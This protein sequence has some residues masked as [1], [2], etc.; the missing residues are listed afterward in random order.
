MR[1]WLP[2][3]FVLLALVAQPPA[4]RCV[5]WDEVADLVKD[6][7]CLAPTPSG[8]GFQALKP[9]EAVQL[10]FPVPKEKPAGFWVGTGSMVALSGKGTSYQLVLRVDAADGPVAYEGPVIRNGDDWNA[11]N[12][13]PVDV[14]A[15][16]TDAHARQG[17]VD[18]FAV[19]LTEGDGWALY[20][21]MKGRP[22]R[23]HVAE[24]TAEFR[25]SLETAKALAERGIAV[26][27]APRKIALREGE[28]RLSA[29]TRI[30]LSAK[31]DADDRFA[32]EDLAEQLSE[33]I[34]AK[35]A[36]TRSD[37]KPAAGTILLR[38]GEGK[39]ESYRLRVAPDGVTATGADA[40]GL[41]YAAQTIAQLVQGKGAEARLPA[42]EVEDSPAYPL[43]ALQYD[44]ARGQ[45]VNVEFM[46]R[47]IR[48]L[49]RCKLNAV[50]FYGEDDYRFVKYP[51]LGREGT[52]TPAKAKELSEYAHRYHL[53]LIPQFES[54][55]HASA[56]L[57]HPE[58]KHL[59]E[60]GSSWVFCTSNPKVWEFLDDCFRE[61]AEQ[62]P[63]SKYLHVGA[64][65]FEDGFG[66]CPQCK[67]KVAQAG[68]PGLY[69]EHM[70]RLNR[71][72][73]KY[74]R[75]ML[76]W[77]S[78]GA[79]TPER[80][81]LTFKAGKLLERDCI[82][83]EW[84]YHGPR[85]YPELRQYLDAG[86]QDCWTS[87]AVVC[88]SVIWPD[89]ETTFRGIRGMLRAGVPEGVKGTCTTTWEWMQGAMV[90]NSWL[91]MMYV[92]ECAW[93][94]GSTSRL[95]YQRR[96]AQRFYGLSGKD[97]GERIAQTLA[98][99]FPAK[100]EGARHRDSRLVRDILWC[101]PAQVRG[102]FA[103]RTGG[104]SAAAPALG[105][106]PAA[107]RERGAALRKDATRN[108]DLLAAAELAFRLHRLAARKVIAFDAAAKAYR[109]AA[110]LAAKEPAAAAAK[111]GEAADVIAALITEHTACTEA[112]EE[113]VQRYG[114]WHGDRD[115]CRRI[116][117][118]LEKLAAGV[119][120]AGQKL[121][122]GE[123]NS[124]PAGAQFG[125]PYG[126]YQRVGVWEPAQMNTETTS[127]R[128]DLSGKVQA[129]GDITLEWTYT[130]GAHALQ[131]DRV[132]LLCDGKEVAADV[133]HGLT[134]A[135]HHGNT[136]VLPLKEFQPAGRYEVVG[137]VR[138][139]GGTDSHGEVWLIL[140]DE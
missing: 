117:E 106:P 86:F 92:P 2:L 19:G 79:G 97:L 12:R 108:A 136:F 58:L 33:A 73:K 50:M 101:E 47:V 70:N 119:R 135:A 133:H 88:Y 51:F 98:R 36:V 100:G 76:F 80:S 128:I 46:K 115:N 114:H 75:T 78:H 13:T 18:V 123:A 20:R 72:C 23:A 131:I 65:E 120:D 66:I 127:L 16:L 81:C 30:Q 107:A 124:L 110:K 140:P 15:A 91:G 116:A 45:T 83:T 84:I 112:F 39:P 69:A 89:Y 52:F 35:V 27:P 87:P 41:F 25:A 67:E 26:I 130:R 138:S 68:L 1:Q 111:A 14:G 32:A 24:V 22:I 55:G 94:L 95:D 121:A 49:A 60:A 93:S 137:T 90:N 118:S 103:L 11:A 10:R 7:E 44:I 54:L 6:H 99:P 53:Q 74:G 17:Y 34:T 126:R 96:F 8:E 113:A 48:E 104:R 9:G 134:G 82:P 125:L 102:R 38:R 5:P 43:R 3:V 29:K 61:L 42:C 21:H 64:D 129:A 40:A 37:G 122:A 105:A 63:H 109:D 59:Q 71:L 85:A 77:P 31:A 132:A 139:H 57:G 62:F 4:G 56:V 28:F